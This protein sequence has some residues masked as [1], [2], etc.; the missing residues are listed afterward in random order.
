ME[1]LLDNKN[2]NVWDITNMVSNVAWKTTRIGRASSLEMTMIKGSPNQDKAFQCN[3][4]DVIR[5]KDGNQ[6]V[7]YGYIFKIGNGK[8]E[9]VKITAYDQ[10]RYLMTNE[11]YVGKNVTATEVIKKIANDLKL[12]L[13]VIEDTKHQIPTLIEDDKKLLDTICKSLDL[14]LIATTQNYVFY[15][16]FGALTLKNIKNMKVDVVIGDES[17]MHDYSYEKSIDD[18]TYNRIKIIR[19]N[20][21]T[22]KRDVYIAE[23]SSNISKWGRLQLLH[24]A[25]EKMNEAQIN[26]L[27]DQLVTLKNREHRKIKISAI[28][29]LRIRAGCFVPIILSEFGFRQY[30]LVDECTHSWEGADHTMSLDLKVI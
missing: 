8:S 16:H 25:D 10:I 15:D 22:G 4:G 2:G 19:D 27:L 26:N 5:L 30:F 18:E 9:E 6:P 12:K 7:F 21:E 11:T 24:K 3:N 13:G 14:T 23:D 29:D 1:I 20:K 17:L 28:G